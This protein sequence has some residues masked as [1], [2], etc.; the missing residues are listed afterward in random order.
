MMLSKINIYFYVS[1]FSSLAS[2]IKISYGISN[3]MNS[4]KGIKFAKNYD[5]KMAPFLI[6]LYQKRGHLNWKNNILES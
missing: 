6:K 1:S 3:L 4:E 2:T 5:F